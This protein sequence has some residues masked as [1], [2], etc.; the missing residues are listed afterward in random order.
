MRSKDTVKE[1]KVVGNVASL[2]ALKH[3]RR[4]VGSLL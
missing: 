4:G 1:T 2:N 3:Q